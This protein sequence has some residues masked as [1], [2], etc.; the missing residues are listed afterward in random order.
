MG[1]DKLLT[2]VASAL[3][4]G[5]PVAGIDDADALRAGGTE[6]VL[7]CTVKVPSTLGTFLRGFQ[8]GHRCQLDRVGREVM[9]RAWGAGVGPGDDTLT[10]D[11]DPSATG[12]RDLRTVQGR[13][14]RHN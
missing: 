8:W 5:P 9:A 14:Q 1:G 4:G 7:G 2:L 3:A 6:Q 13:A 12:G 10:I 11:L